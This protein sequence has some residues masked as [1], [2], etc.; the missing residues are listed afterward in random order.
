M[1]QKRLQRGKKKAAPTKER[2]FSQEKR[3]RLVF[4]QIIRKG[5]KFCVGS[6]E[7]RHNHICGIRRVTDKSHQFI[8]IIPLVYLC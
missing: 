8:F 3:V 4:Q 6:V 5:F 1:M 7:R 2:L